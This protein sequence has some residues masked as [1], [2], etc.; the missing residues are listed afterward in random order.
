[1][2]TAKVHMSEKNIPDVQ[3]GENNDKEIEENNIFSIS[4]EGKKRGSEK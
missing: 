3:T 4:T 2:S 1:M